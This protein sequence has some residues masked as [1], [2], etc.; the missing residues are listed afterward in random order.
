MEDYTPV[1]KKELVY[2][3]LVVL[4][5]AILTFLLGLFS[6]SIVGRV[7]AWFLSGSNLFF[8]L[9]LIFDYITMEKKQ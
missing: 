4:L 9:I 1:T 3:G 2:I 8:L 7:I 6:G 5:V